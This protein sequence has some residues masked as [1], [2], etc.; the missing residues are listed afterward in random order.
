MRVNQASL[1]LV[2][3]F[4]VDPGDNSQERSLTATRRQNFLVPPRR[5]RAFPFAELSGTP[6]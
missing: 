5:N 1:D 4:G 2:N 3:K 6:R